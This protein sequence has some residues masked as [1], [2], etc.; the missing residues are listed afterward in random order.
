[1]D[2]SRS[3]YEQSYPSSAKVTSSTRFEE[4]KRFEN[5]RGQFASEGSVDWTHNRKLLHHSVGRVKKK[6]RG[7]GGG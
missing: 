3:L 1:M 7:E 2:P 5:S 6:N 4:Q